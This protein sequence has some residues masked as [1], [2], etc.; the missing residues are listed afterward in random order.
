MFRG[1][2]VGLNGGADFYAD[3]TGGLKL[4][5]MKSLQIFL[6]SC[7]K[8]GIK[9]TKQFSGRFNVRIS[10]SLHERL[11]ITAE[12]KGISINRLVEDVLDERVRA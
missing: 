7:R 4:E 11:A 2:F 8:R 10:P 9:P 6:D 12:S 5:A 3:D 1:E